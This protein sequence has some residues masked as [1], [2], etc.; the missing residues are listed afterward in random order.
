MN[1]VTCPICDYSYIPS[2]GS[3]ARQHNR[4]C[5]RWQ[6]ACA[7]MGYTPE[8][9]AAREQRKRESASLE[10]TAISSRNRVEAALLYAKALFDR[11]LSTAIFGG[12]WRL[13]PD[14]ETY[15]GML[16]IKGLSEHLHDSH[17][18]DP[19]HIKPGRSYWEPRVSP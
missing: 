8:H 19:G 1:P 13:H 9:Y 11:S 18:P 16:S 14:F 7:E 6:E 17:P 10:L 2:E 3:D 15:V 5:R 4:R 12:Y